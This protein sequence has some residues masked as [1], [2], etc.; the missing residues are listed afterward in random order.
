MILTKNKIKKFDVDFEI[1]QRIKSDRLNQ[2]LII[3]PTNRKIRD[4]K[5]GIITLSPKNATGKI[6]LETLSTLSTK[7]L[8]N[9]SEIKGTI[10]SDAAAT[11][12]LKQSFQE[13]KAKYFSNYKDEI[14]SGTLERIKNVISEYKKNGITA[15]DLRRESESL[16]GSEKLKA[17]DIA[18]IYEKYQ[19]NC[20]KLGVKEIG[21][22]YNQLNRLD[23]TEFE[24][25]FRNFFPEVKVIV[26]QGFDEFTMPEIEIINSTS[27]IPGSEL[28]LSFDYSSSNSQLFKHLDRCYGKL[29]AKGFNPI[30]DSSKS[31][32]NKFQSEIRKNL[33]NGRKPDKINDF[34]K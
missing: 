31:L 26:I 32:H 3:V 27:E 2:L 16:S 5:K 17:E 21:D 33:F 6:N 13:I 18:D 23:K 7:L 1:D 20:D 25:R 11:V 9:D 15:A 12:L 34:K 10:L 29:K 19:A 22:V 14:P 4:L 30:E 24:K 8:F 28:F